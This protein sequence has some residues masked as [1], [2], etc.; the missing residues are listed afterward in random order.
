M[1]LPSFLYTHT[2]THTH[3]HKVTKNHSKP[4]RTDDSQHRGRQLLPKYFSRSNRCAQMNSGDGEE[5]ARGL[6]EV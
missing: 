6:A 1:S 5:G 3:T 2:H 4:A